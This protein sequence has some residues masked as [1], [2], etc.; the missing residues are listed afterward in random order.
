[1]LSAPLRLLKFKPKPQP[2]DRVSQQ[3]IADVRL[4]ALYRPHAVDVLSEIAVKLVE[5]LR[6]KGGAR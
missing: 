2:R 6:Q 4:L 5:P 1:V 3:L